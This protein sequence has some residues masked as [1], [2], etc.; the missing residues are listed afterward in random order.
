MERK[1]KNVTKVIMLLVIAAVAFTSCTTFQLSGAQVTREIPS[2]DTVGEFEIAVKVNEFLGNSGGSNFL[3]AT[4]D[5]M[6]T[7]IYD[8]I[9]R[10]IQK[11]TGDAAV[12]VE[13]RYE[14]SFIDLLLNGLTFS[15]YAPATAHISGVIVK[16]N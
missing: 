15:L 13:I 9:Q 10:E 7:E 14:A 12:N 3:N 6:D 4:S 5:A 11:Y 1:M 16:Y 8:A 2:Y